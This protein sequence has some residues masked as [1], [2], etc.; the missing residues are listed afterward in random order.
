MYTDREKHNL[1]SKGG[2]KWLLYS[3]VKQNKS[4]IKKIA[5]MEAQEVRE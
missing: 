4:R 1:F 5:L 3:I 2:E